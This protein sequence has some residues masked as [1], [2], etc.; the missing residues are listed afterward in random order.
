MS[1]DIKQLLDMAD[2]PEE[3]ANEALMGENMFLSYVP[4]D[5]DHEGKRINVEIAAPN[6]AEVFLKLAVEDQES[7]LDA[8]L[9]LAPAVGHSDTITDARGSDKKRR[10]CRV[11]Q[12]ICE[13][14]GEIQLLVTR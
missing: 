4:R 1:I 6:F 13:T 12:V 10:A 3:H 8:M 9:F 11:T 2:V 14:E 5:G 7:L